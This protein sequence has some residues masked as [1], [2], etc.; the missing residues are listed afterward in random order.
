MTE[1]TRERF[2]AATAKLLQE[3]GYRGTSLNEILAESGAPRGSLYYHFP[4]GK[5]QLAQEATQREAR[6]IS[7]YL[8]TAFRDCPGPVEAVREY[9]E[10]A[11]EHIR[12][13]GFLLGCPV[14]SLVLDSPEASSAIRDLCQEALDEWHQLIRD[15]IADSGI[16]AER[17]DALATLILTS[18]EGA[19]I[20][21]RSRRD[22]EP[23]DTVTEEL[24]AAVSAALREATGAR[25]GDV[26]GVR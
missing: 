18:V 23:L 21:A 25:E 7:D 24:A 3:R 12:T 16:P 15:G 22:P 5:E 6:M 20:L 8:R 26:R 2:L 10:G 1:D 13:G 14:A 4:G 11:R 9:V 17:A 19:L